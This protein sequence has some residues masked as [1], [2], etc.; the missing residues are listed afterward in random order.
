MSPLVGNEVSE[1]MRY[2]I[3][4]SKVDEAAKMFFALNACP[5]FHE[6]LYLKAIYGPNSRISMLASNILKKAEGDFKV[7]AL[8]IFE[9]IISVLGFHHISYHHGENK[10]IERNIKITR[11]ILDVKGKREHE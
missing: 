6:I 11:N 1:D 9:K 5:S 4:K 3:S 10:S 7:K 8:K 2:N